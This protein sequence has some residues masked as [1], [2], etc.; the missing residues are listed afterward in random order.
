[1]NIDKLEGRELDAAVAEAL[2]WEW[3]CPVTVQCQALYSPDDIEHYPLRYKPANNAE[4]CYDWDADL[5][6]YSTDIALDK[7]GGAEASWSIDKCGDQ[8]EVWIYAT[9]KRR[10]GDEIVNVSDFPNVSVAIATAICRAWLKARSI[11]EGGA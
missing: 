9:D 10:R 11:K 4:R 5:P 7:L 6:H 2:G 8:I 1:M 3:R